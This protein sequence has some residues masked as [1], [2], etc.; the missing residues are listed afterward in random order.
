MTLS[1][2]SASATNVLIGFFLGL[3]GYGLAKLFLAGAWAMAVGVVLPFLGL[4]IVILLSNRLSDRLLRIGT[5]TARTPETRDGEPLPR[6]L[7]M[8]AGFLLGPLAGMLGLTETIV[9]AL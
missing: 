5:N 2:W 9:G 1:D 7:G 6:A 4:L 3:A 8:P